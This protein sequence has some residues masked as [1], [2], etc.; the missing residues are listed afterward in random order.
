MNTFNR[1]STI[2][3]SIVPGQPGMAIHNGFNKTA[4]FAGNERSFL[5]FHTDENGEFASVVAFLTETGLRFRGR[6]RR[7]DNE[8]CKNHTI[9][10]D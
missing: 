4:Y 9:G 8:Y 2:L 6:G 5:F 10:T 1:A 7:D 3:N